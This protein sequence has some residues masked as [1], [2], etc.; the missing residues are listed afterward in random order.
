MK[1]KSPDQNIDL[2]IYL[3]KEG[4]CEHYN[5]IKYHNIKDNLR[6][7]GFVI[8]NPSSHLYKIREDIKEQLCDEENLPSEFVFLKIIGNNII[9]TE[10]AELFII[11]ATH[12]NRNKIPISTDNVSDILQKSLL[13]SELTNFNDITTKNEMPSEYENDFEEESEYNS[14]DEM[15][16][17]CNEINDIDTNGKYNKY[18]NNEEI[19]KNKNLISQRGDCRYKEYKN[20]APKI[21]ELDEMN[22]NGLPYINTNCKMIT[23]QKRK[24][25]LY[26]S[27]YDSPHIDNKSAN[28]ESVNR[29]KSP[30][31]IQ[32]KFRLREELCDELQRVR[33]ERKRL[34]NERECILHKAKMKT[35]KFE[36]KNKSNYTTFL[37]RLFLI[38][39]SDVWQRRYHTQFIR[40]KEIENNNSILHNDLKSLHSQIMN[41]LSQMEPSN[42]YRNITQLR[43]KNNIQMNI[44]NQINKTEEE[45]CDIKQNIENVKRK[46][47]T[48]TQLRTRADLE[49]KAIKNNLT[50]KKIELTLSRNK[51]KGYIDSMKHNTKPN[52]SRL[53]MYN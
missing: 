15:K 19:Y 46:L 16:N 51:N 7:I 38:L 42:A 27:E 30:Y 13:S 29:N 8:T 48:E 3:I 6:P 25:N 37:T 34:E 11:E 17:S 53:R 28:I 36:N 22:N 31:M 47:Q 35:P 26:K 2:M 24:K 23:K 50:E 32:D 14:D 40:T 44:L 33:Q 5:E 18:F 43:P 4:T 20:Y 1:E 21:F 39:D 9:R 10:N 12:L 45:I 52:T 49:L 41:N